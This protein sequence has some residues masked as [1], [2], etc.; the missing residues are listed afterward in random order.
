MPQPFSKLVTDPHIYMEPDI[1]KD[2][3]DLAI[4]VTQIFAVWA[5]IEYLQKLLFVQILG[6]ERTPAYAMYE[7]LTSDNQRARA[8]EAAAKSALTTEDYEVFQAVISVC[9][10]SQTERNRLAHWTW[11]GC[12]QRPDML[13]LI[14]P[15]MIKERDIR[16]A[17]YY[18][19][20]KF[21]PTQ[22]DKMIALHNFDAQH[23]LGYTKTD[24]ERALR[25]LM[26]AVDT[27]S[28]FEN[29]LDP[30]FSRTPLAHAVAKENP[31]EIRDEIFRRLN[32]KR[33]F[34]EALARIR[35]DRKNIP[36]PP[37]IPPEPNPNA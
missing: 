3:P 29:Y 25:D 18:S 6:V 17:R 35:E 16:V 20:D 33:L 12:K 5:R 22:F 19:K 9:D 26:D 21:D 23:V 8:L 27:V 4:L 10:S 24:L 37:P 2:K 11:G 14:D 13:A 32:E 31:K 28:L 36:P 15:T 7:A 30:T 1:L 34:R